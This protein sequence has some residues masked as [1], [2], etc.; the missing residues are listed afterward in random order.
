MVPRGAG[1][2]KFAIDG[3]HFGKYGYTY[4]WQAIYGVGMDSNTLFNV[5]ADPTRL[6]V[7]MLIQSE[8]EA[9]VC[10]LTHALRE[11]QPKISR[12][13]AYLRDAHVVCARRE[14][15]WMHYRLDPELQSWAAAILAEAHRQLRNSSPFTA[16]L[17]RLLRMKD[18]PE[19]ACA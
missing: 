1:V 12:H 19:R 3:R 15:T 13:L 17:N 14:G 7:I 10:E 16:D 2:S 6:R 11:S 18:R 5:L 9:C 4:I 8:G